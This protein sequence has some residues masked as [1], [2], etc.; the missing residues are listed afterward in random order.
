M[1]TEPDQYFIE[2]ILLELLERCF[3][4]KYSMIP[5]E[6]LKYRVELLMLHN[7]NTIKMKIAERDTK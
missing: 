4:C 2:G 7:V 5:I 3:F 6:L 1:K